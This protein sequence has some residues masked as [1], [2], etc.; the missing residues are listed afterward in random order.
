M[1]YTRELKDKGYQIKF[2]KSNFDNKGYDLTIN[3]EKGAHYYQAFYSMSNSLGYFFTM[4]YNDCNEDGCNW[5]FDND[6]LVC[7]F[8]GADVLNKI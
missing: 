5:D 1:S 2:E 4:D 6:K 7:E 3:V 8:I